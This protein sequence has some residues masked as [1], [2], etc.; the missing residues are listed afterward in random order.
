MKA[1]AVTGLIIITATIALYLYVWHDT[2]KFEEGLG[3]LSERDTVKAAPSTS[4][5]D[6]VSRQ[7]VA[8]TDP[9]E[10]NESEH[11]HPHAVPDR[12]E[13]I[14]EM[15]S[16]DMSAP[17]SGADLPQAPETP[18]QSAKKQNRKIPWGEATVDQQIANMRSW[19]VKNHDNTAEIDEYLRLQRIFMESSSIFVNISPEDSLRHLELAAKLYPGT[20]NEAAYQ[21]VLEVRKRLKNG[22]FRIDLD[23]AEVVPIPINQ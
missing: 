3:P 20:G 12:H 18:N 2:K 7:T 17:V 16:E 9:A 8:E 21:R 4:A 23:N 10:P 22:T 1:Y 15:P 5:V 11:A 14:A 6:G 13:D 19:L